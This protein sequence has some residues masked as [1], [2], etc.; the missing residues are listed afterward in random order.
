MK[1]KPLTKEQIIISTDRLTRFKNPETKYLRVF[2]EII[3]HNLTEPKFSKTDLESLDYEEVKK[4][5]Q[6][7]VNNSLV[8]LGCDCEND[9]EINNKLSEYEKSVYKVD[10]QTQKLLDNN[11]NY[12]AILNFLDGDIPKNLQWLKTLATSQNI[13]ELR[14]SQAFQFPIEVLIL[15]EGATEETLL[16]EF[17]KLCDFDFDKE[18]VYL[19]ASGGK[20]QVVK[21]YY[22]FADCLKIPIFVLFDKDGEENAQD[23]KPKLRAQDK[24]HILK[25]GEFEDILPDKLFKRSL[26]Y[27][28]QNIST[29][30]TEIDASCPRVKILED[31]FKKRGMHELKKAEFAKTVKANLQSAEDVSPEMNDIIEEIKSLKA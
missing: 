22:E 24:I 16:P 23:I 11:I 3:L 1:I 29:P 5:A 14:K 28:L 25:C 27:E 30:A 21:S 26:D 15:T 4:I 10:E 31:I 19:I 2:Y 7:V 8:E 13:C 6:D 20:N 9:L 18:G 17:A 12:R